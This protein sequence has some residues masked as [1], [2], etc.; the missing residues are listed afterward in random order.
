[1]LGIV[2][3]LVNRVD[4]VLLLK[5]WNLHIVERQTQNKYTCWHIIRSCA[6]KG[7]W[8][9]LCKG[10]IGKPE[11]APETKCDKTPANWRQW[12]LVTQQCL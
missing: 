10:P 9:V 3:S 12:C 5:E 2:K 4:K 6:L 8:K 11:L 1:M 7:K